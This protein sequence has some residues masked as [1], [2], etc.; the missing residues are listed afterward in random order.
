MRKMFL[1]LLLTFFWLNLQIL[2][3]VWEC[4]GMILAPN[5]TKTCKRSSDLRFWWKCTTGRQ[6]LSTFERIL[7]HCACWSCLGPTF[8]K[9][10]LL[11][12]SS[13]R[14]NATSY[15]EV[16]FE[17]YIEGGSDVKSRNFLRVS[18]DVA[19]IEGHD[20]WVHWSASNILKPDWNFCDRSGDC[21]KRDEDKL[22]HFPLVVVA[23][24]SWNLEMIRA[25]VLARSFI[26]KLKSLTKFA[27]SFRQYQRF[28]KN[29]VL[30]IL[31]WKFLNLTVM[32][33]PAVE[34]LMTRAE[35]NS[36]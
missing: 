20:F 18:L 4:S 32:L 22:E 2:D 3:I 1:T 31:I 35:V 30:S 7:C 13:L 10:T 16:I 27:D 6:V 24:C 11:L 23:S 8:C 9:K 29:C 25:L 34:F 14:S 19:L 17:G 36:F 33:E 15:H 12:L 5:R 28:P 21:K 26:C